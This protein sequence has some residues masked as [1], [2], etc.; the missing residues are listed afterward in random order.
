MRS[1]PSKS[2]LRTNTNENI[3]PNNTGFNHPRMSPV[4]F[5]DHVHPTVGTEKDGHVWVGATVPSGML[6]LGVDTDHSEVGYSYKG[7]IYGI[8]HVHVSGT[9]GGR[10]YQNFPFSPHWTFD[11]SASTVSPKGPPLQSRLDSTRSNEIARPGFYSTTLNEPHVSIA[12]TASNKVGLHQWTMSPLSVVEEELREKE[13]LKKVKAKKKANSKNKENLMDASN[14][15]DNDG[16]NDSTIETATFHAF[17][18]VSHDSMDYMHASVRF[19]SN[20]RLVLSGRFKDPWAN[21]L[22]LGGWDRGNYDMHA[23]VQFSNTNNKTEKKPTAFGVWGESHYTGYDVTSKSISTNRPDGGSGDRG[24]KK[25]DKNN[26]FQFVNTFDAEKGNRELSVSAANGNRGYSIGAYVSYRFDLK[27]QENIDL[28]KFTVEYRVGIS[29]ISTDQACVNLDAEKD[30]S[31][32]DVQK[33]AQVLWEE[34]VSSISVSGPLDDADMPLLYTNLYRTFLMPVD[35]SGENPAWSEKDRSE[36]P[37]YDDFYCIWDTFRT[38]NPLLTLIAPSLESRLLNSLITTAEYTGGLL[39]DSLVGNNWAIVQ[40]GSNADVLISEAMQK[41]LAGVNYKAAFKLL[42][43]EMEKEASDYLYQGRG[44]TKE[45]KELGYVPAKSAYG[46]ASHFH[47]SSGSRTVE[48]AYG[49]FA[50]GEI[51]RR[52]GYEEDAKVFRKRSGN[53]KN[54]WNKDVQSHGFTGFLMPKFN[55]EFTTLDPALGCIP[56]RGGNAEFYE[57][58]SWTYSF[59]APQNMKDVIEFM[60]GDKEFIARVDAFFNLRIYNPGNE[61]GFL[62]PFLYHYVGRPD[63]S[64]ERSTKITDHLFLPT[65]DGLPGN[66]DAGTMAAL[67][68]FWSLGLFPIAGQD[69]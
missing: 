1:D 33:R 10:S 60:G 8:S 11:S 69:I 53:W 65:S 59:Y 58:C 51:A 63:L 2:S 35:K 48:Y 67:H 36:K 61:P 43:N 37:Y 12:L 29:H 23:C 41:N 15:H 31:F 42:K 46:V 22:G 16:A 50:I 55:D 7:R 4:P 44:N 17:F 30:Y 24:K 52:L 26:R 49:D 6:K 34:A 14:N 47:R 57:D 27:E 9:G 32:D 5:L 18:K 40:S 54:L 20:D 39:G 13:Q 64:V 68:I 56:S 28:T 19:L 62:V 21:G 38:L 66:D 45:W 25:Q 3:K